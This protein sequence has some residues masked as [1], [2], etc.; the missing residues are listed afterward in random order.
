MRFALSCR[1][2]FE[3]AEC[4]LPFKGRAEAGEGDDEDGESDADDE[5]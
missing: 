1:K 2:D 3:F 4:Q 5:E